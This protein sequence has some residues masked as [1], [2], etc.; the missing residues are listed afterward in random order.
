[1]AEPA[2]RRPVGTGGGRQARSTAR[3]A[4][5]QALYQMEIAGTDVRQIL[6][7][8]AAGTVGGEVDGAEL[9]APDQAFLADLVTG[10]V[11]EQARLDPEIDACLSEGW[12]LGRVDSILRAILRAGAYELALRRDV[13]FKATIDEY[14]DIAHAFFDGP[15]TKVVN[16][17]LDRLARQYGRG[18]A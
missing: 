10:I 11:R 15:E 14:V 8:R 9:A 6:A 2:P 1:M 7:E 12:S 4:C 16:G 13:P 3:L 17:V 5:V 18:P